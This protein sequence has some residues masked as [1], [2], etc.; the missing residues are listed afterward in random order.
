MNVT[1]LWWLSLGAAAAVVAVVAGLLGLVIT[2]ARSIDRRAEDIWVVG[3]QIAGNTVSIW[4]LNKTND[5][6]ASMLDST[7]AIERATTSM[8]ERLRSLARTDGRE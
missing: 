8:D 6:V 3:K 2:A 1:R 5:H 4:M 7:R